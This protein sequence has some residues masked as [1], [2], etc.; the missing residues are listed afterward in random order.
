MTAY[1]IDTETTGF[2]E[3][4]LIEF[5]SI[6]FELDLGAISTKGEYYEQFEPTKAIEYGALCTHNI[7]PSEL[8]TC[9]HHTE[10]KLPEDAT[11]LIGH[12]V[13]YD[14]SV[15][16]KPAIKRICTKA[17]ASYLYP[18]LDSHRQNAMMYFFFGDDA[19]PLV[20]DAHNALCDVR[21]CLRILAEMLDK[22]Q[23]YSIEALWEASELA[24]IPTVMPFGKHKGEPIKTIPESYVHW[25]RNQ[26]DVDMYLLKAFD[27]RYAKK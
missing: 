24:R 12:N 23:V 21:N 5:A 2:K 17:L 20:K 10:F 6:E 13:D 16:G 25:L 26:P 18:E 9:R 7:L 1:I 3:P 4:E 11:Y 19:K 22:L 8:T 15:I 14:W 27:A